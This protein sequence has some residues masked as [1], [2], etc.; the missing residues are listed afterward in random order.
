MASLMNSWNRG[1]LM[2]IMFEDLTYE[3]QMRLL[4]EAGV[5]SPNETGWDINP[6]AIIN[7]EKE[8]YRRQGKSMDNLYNPDPDVP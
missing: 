7:L 5:E 1:L 4:A 2:K 8:D 3:A 6:I